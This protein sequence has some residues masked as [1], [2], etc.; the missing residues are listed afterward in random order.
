MSKKVVSRKE[1]LQLVGQKKAT[2]YRTID[3]LFEKQLI[4]SE[5]MEHNEY[6]AGRP[7]ELFAINR[8]MNYVV[9]ICIERYFYKLAIM[10]LA[11]DFLDAYQNE[12]SKTTTPESFAE[13]IY[14]QYLQ[15]CTKGSIEEDKILGIG[16][17]TVGPLDSEHGIITTPYLY[18]GSGWKN[19][20]IKQILYNKFSKPVIVDNLARAGI[21]GEYRFRYSGKCSNIAYVTVGR[22]IGSSLITNGAIVRGKNWAINGLGHMVIDVDG[23]Q[24]VCG[25]YGCLEAY[26]TIPAIIREIE[27]QIK[28]GRESELKSSFPNITIEQ[29]CLA[30]KHKDS[31]VIE[32]MSEASFILTKALI[33]LLR[34][35]DLEAILLTGELIR[36]CP[37]FFLMTKE[38]LFKILDGENIEIL[39][40]QEECEEDVVLRGALGF[41]LEH[42]INE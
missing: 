41:I 30:L 33:N 32:V 20:P 39:I 25:S 18:T 27:S 16:V 24:C 4:I 23:K 8:D 1:L 9:G 3:S 7:S 12:F 6:G 40:Q 5:G 36:K 2:L 17:G 38:N 28:K 15:M 35:I 37:E 19:V 11:G 31:L 10:N 13:D 42:S 26:S 22:A 14:I 29:V 34:M 21:M